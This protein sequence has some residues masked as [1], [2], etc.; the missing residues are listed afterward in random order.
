MPQWLDVV[1]V[2]RVGY[3]AR[4][5]DSDA[6]PAPPAL[7]DQQTELVSVPLSTEQP[8]PVP[9]AITPSAAELPRPSAVLVDSMSRWRT[10]APGEPRLSWT[11]GPALEN[12]YGR[13]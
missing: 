4:A 11:G 13:G 1:V 8:K 6:S 2:H 12:S 5:A 10:I 7:A 3:R 9:W